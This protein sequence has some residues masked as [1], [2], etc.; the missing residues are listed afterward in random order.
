M[1]RSLPQ[2]QNAFDSYKTGRQ[3]T[4]KFTEA[5]YGPI[6]H[7]ILDDLRNRQFSDSYGSLRA[8]LASFGPPAAIRRQRTLAP[9]GIPASDSEADSSSSESDSDSNSDSDSDSSSTSNGSV[10]DSHRKK[11]H[12]PSESLSVL[13][14]DQL[15]STD[16]RISA[17]F[18]GRD[19]PSEYFPL[20]TRSF[21]FLDHR[22]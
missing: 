11:R 5:T 16:R 8:W 20:I 12:L 9:V 3:L 7:S 10:E 13:L 21:L 14:A 19:S 18:A 15:S 4:V 22:R 6:Y 1:F 17:S 2:I